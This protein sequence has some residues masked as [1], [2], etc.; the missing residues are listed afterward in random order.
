MSEAVAP[1]IEDTQGQDVH[2]EN[3][4]I[5]YPTSPWFEQGRNTDPDEV[6]DDLGRY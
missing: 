2:Q 5:S 4:N 6:A 1:A 3:G